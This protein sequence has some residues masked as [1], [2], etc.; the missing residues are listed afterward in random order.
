MQALA[1]WV[2]KVW[3]RAGR[4]T[5]GGSDAHASDVEFVWS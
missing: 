1:L 3:G 2:L 4:Q 5:H